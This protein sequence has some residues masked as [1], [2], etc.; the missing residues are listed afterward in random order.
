MK[1]VVVSGGF[2]PVHIGHLRLFI[3]ARA[4]GSHL[5][6]ILNSDNFLIEKKG[7]YF[8]PFQERKEILLGFSAVDEVI[9]SLDTDNTVRKSI[10][11]L[12]KNDAIDIFANGGDRKDIEDIPEYEICKNNDIEM[13]FDIGGE[14]IQSSSNLVDQFKSYKEERPWGKF[15]NLLEENNFLVKKLSVRPNQKLSLQYHNERS[16]FWVVVNG[17]GVIT[18]E[19]KEIEC[20]PGSSFFIK[21]K[22]KHRIENNGKTEL[23]LIEVQLGDDLSEDDIVRIEDSYGRD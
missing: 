10:E 12:A 16:E 19:E 3:K 17:I 9:E 13:I 4:L 22:Q 23:E 15:E 18:I 7:F 14:K 5:T 2:D 1:K 8:M 11:M 21:K 6:V 20:N